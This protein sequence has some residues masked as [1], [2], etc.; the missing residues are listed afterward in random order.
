MALIICKG[1]YNRPSTFDGMVTCT[2]PDWL[3]LKSDIK[4]PGLD[5]YH[6]R[7][8]GRSFDGRYQRGS[9]LTDFNGIL[10]PPPKGLNLVGRVP[11]MFGMKTHDYKPPDAKVQFIKIKFGQLPY[12]R[13]RIITLNQFQ[14]FSTDRYDVN[15]AKGAFVKSLSLIHI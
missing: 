6:R 5:T 2:G 14:I 3:A 11:G 13:E 4:I 15:A 12:L 8:G 10:G 7:G 1:S 9:W